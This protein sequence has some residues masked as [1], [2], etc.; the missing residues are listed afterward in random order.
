MLQFNSG[1]GDKKGYQSGG[2]NSVHESPN[3][4]G[5]RKRENFGEIEISMDEESEFGQ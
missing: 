3:V 2:F 4:V 1:D 5:Y